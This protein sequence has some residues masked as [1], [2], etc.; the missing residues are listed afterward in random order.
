MRQK[1]SR[2]VQHKLFI[3]QKE[4]KNEEGIVTSHKRVFFSSCGKINMILTITFALA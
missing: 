3:W 4:T 1:K 2:N